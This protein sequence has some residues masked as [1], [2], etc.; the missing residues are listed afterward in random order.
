MPY[1]EIEVR[2]LEIDPVKLKQKLIG[3]GA[4]DNGDVL[5]EEVIFYDKD[6]KWRDSEGKF[7]RLRKDDKRI[8]LSYKHHQSASTD[9]VEEIEFEVGDMARAEA[10]L[11]RVGL[12]AYRHQQKKRHSFHLGNMVAD[13][14]TWPRIPT[15][16]ELEG[17]SEEALK[18]FASQLGLDWDRAVFKSAR[19]VIEQDYHVP[20]GNMKWF[21]FD[22]FE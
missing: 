14:D 11:E 5:L 19:E 3:L 4:E 16:V 22:K 15:Y 7:V 2:F 9:G 21:T 20:V 17:I 12:V 13:I 18:Q 8:S 1:R 6:M 10:F